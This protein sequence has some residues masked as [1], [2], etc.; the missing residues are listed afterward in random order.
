MDAPQFN[1]DDN[2]DS[3]SPHQPPFCESC[4]VGEGEDCAAGCQCVST[5]G[6]ADCR[7]KEWAEQDAAEHP[8]KDAT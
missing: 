1:G 8:E 3:L 6:C 4:G 7:A 2:R 5:C